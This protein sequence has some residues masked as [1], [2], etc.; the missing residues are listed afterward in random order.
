MK[1]E[2]KDVFGAGWK[3][4]YGLAGGCGFM[5]GGGVGWMR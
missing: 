5:A 3:T 4:M 1:G 2:E